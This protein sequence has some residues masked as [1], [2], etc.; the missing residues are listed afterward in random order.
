MHAFD[1]LEIFESRE[2]SLRRCILHGDFHAS[3]RFINE[4]QPGLACGTITDT[5]PPRQPRNTQNSAKR[6]VRTVERTSPAPVPAPLR[7]LRT[8][9]RPSGTYAP[10]P[11]VDPR[12]ERWS[13]FSVAV[14]LRNQ[15]VQE[16][17][18]QSRDGDRQAGIRQDAAST[19]QRQYIGDVLSIDM[20]MSAAQAVQQLWS[21]QRSTTSTCLREHSPHQRQDPDSTP[22]R[23]CKTGSAF[24]W[25]HTIRPV[26]SFGILHD[27]A[28]CSPAG[29]T[30][31]LNEMPGAR[32]STADRNLQHWRTS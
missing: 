30:R 14:R 16:V 18:R 10:T 5:S 31:G 23:V 8:G 24:V 29:R 4:T 1:Y 26:Y 21:L 9:A 3:H 11:F 22:G 20:D 19:I 6:Y 28:Q 17:R 15:L 25:I 7:L 27:F 32:R 2:G 12:Y 13:R